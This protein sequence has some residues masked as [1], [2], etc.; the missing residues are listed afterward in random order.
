MWSPWQTGEECVGLSQW[1]KGR[2]CV[3]VRGCVNESRVSRN[4]V[5]VEFI[6]TTEERGGNGGDV[7]AAR[8]PVPRPRR[9]G[10]GW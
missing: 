10:T 3:C 9:Q 1:M 6:N 2:A 4:G 8:V 7:R 5:E